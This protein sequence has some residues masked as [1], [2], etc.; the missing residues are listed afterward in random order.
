MLNKQFLALIFVLL[1]SASVLAGNLVVNMAAFTDPAAATSVSPVGGN[2]GTTIGAQRINLFNYAAGIW[3][4]ILQPSVNITIDAQ[5]SSMTCGPTSA[6]LG[7][8]GPKSSQ[9]NFSGAPYTNTWYPRALR[10][11]IAGSIFNGEA[12]INSTFNSQ[13]EGNAGCLGGWRWYYGYDHNPGANQID[14]LEIVLHEMG[15]GL[16]FITFT[17]L[18]TGAKASGF[19]DIYMKFLRDNSLNKSWPAMTDT[20]RKASAKD[21]GDL[22]WTGSQVQHMLPALF[23]GTTNNYPRMY[24]PATLSTGSSVNHWDTNVT[25]MDNSNEL[26]EYSYATPFDMALTVALMRDLGWANAHYDYDGDGTEDLPDDYP[27]LKAADTDTDGDGMA[28]TWLAGSGCSSSSCDGLALDGDDDGDGVP[29]AVDAAALDAAN[30]NEVNLPL[31][32]NY[33]GLKYNSDKRRN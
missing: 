17:N 6:V 2:P 19:D 27:H 1:H 30:K 9:L 5:F 7:N 22:V 11:H 32:G 13:I 8:A 28:D 12:A 3:T 10:D 24:A 29:D 14:L 20:E 26:M 16:G 31:A 18:S 33:K 15:H 23:D 25:Y 21:T 4:G